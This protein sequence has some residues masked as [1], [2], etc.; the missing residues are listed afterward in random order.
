MEVE[1]EVDLEGQAPQASL[2]V[3]R[4]AQARGWGA[5]GSVALREQV[6]VG[7]M[8]AAVGAWI[9]LANGPVGPQSP[10]GPIGSTGAK[11]EVVQSPNR[12]RR[13]RHFS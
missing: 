12:Q 10:V 7:A 8:A 3:Q 11:V 4:A 1:E 13:R 5:M 9:V 2:V 6:S